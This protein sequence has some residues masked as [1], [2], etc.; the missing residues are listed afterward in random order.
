M[1]RH[2][3]RISQHSFIASV[4]SPDSIVFDFG[5]NQGQ[6]AL[7]V[8]R[9]YGCRV[10]GA[11][12]V[13]ELFDAVERHDRLALHRVAIGEN[14][15]AVELLVNDDDVLS[16]TVL[17][18]GTAKSVLG[19]EDSLRTI[20]ETCVGLNEFR[21]LNHVDRIDLVKVDIEG[22][23]L[24]LFETTS[25][26]A[27]RSCA[28]LTVEFHDYWY[29]D[30]ANRTKQAK[31]RLCDL[32]FRMIRF[33][34]NNKDV[35]F[36]NPEEIKLSDSDWRYLTTVTRNVNLCGRAVRVAVRRLMRLGKAA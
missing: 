33:T 1:T 7:N 18:H 35:L 28:Q 36:V 22:A 9:K 4:L 14:G 3:D 10:F 17:E 19:S 25:D 2:L 23:E 5:V 26:E 12:P 8:I 20:S 34:P 30:L 21:Q 15:K 6:F 24:D 13:H 16:S 32:G 29:P 27:F 31:E 11:E